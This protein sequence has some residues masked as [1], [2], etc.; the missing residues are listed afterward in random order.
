MFHAL[1]STFC[2]DGTELTVTTDVGHKHGSETFQC[3]RNDGGYL[4]E[5]LLLGCDGFPGTRRGF[6]AMELVNVDQQE[7]LVDKGP[8]MSTDKVGYQILKVLLL[9]CGRR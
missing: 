8:D 1:T 6:I 2:Q 9:L 5:Q 3:C 7:L 4:P